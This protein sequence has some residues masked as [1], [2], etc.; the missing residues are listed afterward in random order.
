M[1]LLY[2]VRRLPNPT[3]F[4]AKTDR[5]AAD[6]QVRPADWRCCAPSLGCH[7]IVYGVVCLLFFTRLVVEVAGHDQA[8][9]VTGESAVN[10]GI[11]MTP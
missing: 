1:A 9:R 4:Q 2:V 11:K 10:N 8:F 5:Q 7:S 6:Q 3:A